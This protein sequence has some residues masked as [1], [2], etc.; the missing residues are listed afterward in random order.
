EILPISQLGSAP[1]Q[2][3]DA[4]KPRTLP[5]PIFLQAAIT[6]FLCVN[7]QVSCYRWWKR[8]IRRRLAD[9]VRQITYFLAKA[10]PDAAV[11]VFDDFLLEAIAGCYPR[12]II[13]IGD[14]P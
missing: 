2:Q 9:D 10:Q 5:C 14:L 13:A 7:I 11:T 1:G 6:C 8:A 3:T 12:L 4:Y